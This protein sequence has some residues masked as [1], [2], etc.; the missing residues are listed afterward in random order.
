MSAELSR[1]FNQFLENI[2]LG[3]PQVTRMNSAAESVT[4][5]L[6][7]R[8]GVPAQNV[9]MQGSYANRT[10]IEPVNG[11][12]YDIDLVSVCVGADMT[13][14]RALN[15]MEAVFRSDGR[16]KDRVRRKKPCVRLEYANDEVGS[17]HVDV[18]PARISGA[19]SPPLE[20]P[21]RG[22]GWLGTAPAEYTHWCRNQGQL[23]RRTV[24]MMKRWRD[25]QQ[26]VRNAI[27]SIVLQVL[28]AQCMPQVVD[29]GHRLAQTFRSLHDSL[30][31]LQ[32]PPVVP[33]PVLPGENLARS[34]TAESFSSFVKELAEAVEWSN[35]ALTT[36]DVVEA[37]DAWREL[38]GDNFPVQPP[39]Q[40][41][42]QLGDL[43]H[44][45]SPAEMGWSEQ[46]DPR[47]GV[48]IEAS[49]QRG[50]RGQGRRRLQN[51]GETLFQ[52]LKLQFKANV[53]AP[54]HVDIWW[55]VAN[56]GGHARSEG[57]LRGEIF[58]GKDL[59]NRPI[60]QDENWES[61]RF[62]GSH[63]V[64]ALLVREQRV[65]AVS[66]WFRVNIWAR[67]RAFRL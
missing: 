35:V 56:T 38:L 23:Y 59:K 25:E 66:D 42:L 55:Q 10:S 27:K 16:F 28:V 41:G 52:D 61:T 67:G 57:Q 53:I 7:E 9:F 40:L 62:T 54:R 29:D 46:L 60:A 17:F 50:K 49:V 39:N 33:N 63:L 24:M 34:W 21:R 19:A 22:Q 51:N 8:Y 3:E 64:R 26:S 48:T 11:G 45:R 43:S 44:A 58:K 18:V 15:E 2:S 5:F 37:A 30:R 20:A 14:D 13:S 4:Q 32:S 12:E 1:Y 31:Q 47:Y 65:V 36:T 6:L